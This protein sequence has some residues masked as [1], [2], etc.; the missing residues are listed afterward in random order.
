VYPDKVCRGY[1]TKWGNGEER[2]TLQEDLDR[3]EE[4]VNK[5]LMK[6]NTEKF[7]VLHLGKH[8]PGVPHRLGSTCR[9]SSS[10]ERNLGVLVD[11]KCKTSEQCAAVAKKANR[12][13][14]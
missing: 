8:N 13:L 5:N 7:K 2:A 3:L 11:N 9:W 4:W 12:M 1:Q 6:C 14:G 10:V